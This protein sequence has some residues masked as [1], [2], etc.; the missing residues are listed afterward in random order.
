MRIWKYVHVA[1]D[2]Y[3]FDMDTVTHNQLCE[4]K[5]ASNVIEALR[6]S[7]VGYEGT[8]LDR[9]LLSEKVMEIQ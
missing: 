5:L 3:V 1:F 6:K 2:Q 7:N 8:V 4:Q 9:W